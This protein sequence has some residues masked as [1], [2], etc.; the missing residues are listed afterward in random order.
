MGSENQEVY[1]AISGALLNPDDRSFGVYKM[2]ND[3]YPAFAKKLFQ[4]NDFMQRLVM[5]GHNPIDILDYPICGKCETLALMDGFSLKDGKYYPKSTCVAEKCGHSTVNPVTLRDWIK[6]ELRKKAPKEFFDIIEIVVDV[7][8][9]S[10]IRKY[11]NELRTTLSASS[12]ERAKAIIM[13]DG[14]SHDVDIVH[15]EARPDGTDSLIF[16]KE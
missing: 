10:M 15:A 4:N 6:D 5:S 1:S 12:A 16:E 9:N 7:V 8:A 2:L 14:S 3:V 11:T 13:P